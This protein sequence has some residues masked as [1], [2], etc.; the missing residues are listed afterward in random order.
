LDLSFFRHLFFFPLFYIHSFINHIR[1][2]KC[3]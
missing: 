2:D 1:V 3:V